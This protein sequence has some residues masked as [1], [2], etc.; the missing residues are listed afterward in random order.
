MSFA[1]VLVLEAE[2]AMV[3][4]LAQVQQTFQVVRVQAAAVVEFLLVLFL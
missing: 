1:E 4:L 3:L 2:V